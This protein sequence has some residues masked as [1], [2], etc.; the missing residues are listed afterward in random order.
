MILG[1]NQQATECTVLA[2][3][4]APAVKPPGP[5]LAQLA[6]AGSHPGAELLTCCVS[7]IGSEGKSTRITENKSEKQSSGEKKGSLFKFPAHVK[8][9]PLNKVLIILEST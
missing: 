3:L 8:A 9:T 2:G 7:A 5:L 6:A 4:R 1:R